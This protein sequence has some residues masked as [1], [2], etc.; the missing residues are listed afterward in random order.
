MLLENLG[1]LEKTFLDSTAPTYSVALHKAYAVRWRI[2]IAVLLKPEL[3]KPIDSNAAGALISEI[4]SAMMELKHQADTTQEIAAA[5]D[6]ARAFIA[7]E[8]VA[9]SEQIHQYE[10]S[11]EQQAVA[12]ARQRFSPVTTAAKLVVTETASP[13]RQ[14]KG[15]FLLYGALVVSLIAAI[16]FHGI[17][18][19]STVK[20]PR[21][22]LTDFYLPPGAVALPFVKDMITVTTP[23]PLT[24]EEKKKFKQSVVA[25]GKEFSEVSPSNFIISLAKPNG[26]N[27]R[28]FHDATPT[29]TKQQ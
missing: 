14:K 10:K 20:A 25:V 4:D 26:K 9:F 22:L 8:A 29:P 5:H 24:P 13:K 11:I 15:R 12:L 18:L 7:K 3:G 1:T 19:S 21:P 16:C 27:T 2:A 23:K 17:R 6:A 28:G